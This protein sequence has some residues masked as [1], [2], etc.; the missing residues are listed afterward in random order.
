[1]SHK[2][3]IEPN[4]DTAY[5]RYSQYL[6]KA[7]KSI[8]DAINHANNI[9]Y[10]LSAVEYQISLLTTI[11]GRLSQ[12][13]IDAGKA[14]NG[15]VSQD[16]SNAETI[17]RQQKGNTNYLDEVASLSS[18]KYSIIG[19]IPFI[20]MVSDDLI[21]ASV[22]RRYGA[23]PLEQ[24][25]GFVF[26]KMLA[27]KNNLYNLLTS[28]K[29]TASNKTGQDILIKSLT[30]SS[31]IEA[32]AGGANYA[33]K[34]RKRYIN[35]DY[36]NGVTATKELADKLDDIGVKNVN[37]GISVSETERVTALARSSS[38]TGKFV[39]TSLVKNAG[40]AGSVGAI[41]SGGIEA[42]SGY[43][44]YKNGTISGG[45]YA[46]NV[47]RESTAGFVGAAVTTTLTGFLTVTTLPGIAV[48]AIGIGSGIA[49][50]AGVS[51][52]WKKIA[53]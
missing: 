16:S 36:P 43:Q 39:T 44:D 50:S 24:A 34:I 11:K 4:S 41:F 20:P 15:L 35:G 38:S 8:A 17:L 7:Q 47:A 45:Q 29:V 49:I 40:K 52:L 28:A 1:M 37:S 3:S 27:R 13:V 53:G 18:G 46:N 42:L 51:W 6:S 14:V 23:L 12:L 5:N 19:G 33:Y 30:N 31:T 25:K 22:I 21:S 2:V 48:A 10:D 9:R 26:E 32:K